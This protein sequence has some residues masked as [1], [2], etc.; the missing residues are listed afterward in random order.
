MD[1]MSGKTRPLVRGRRGV[2]AAGHPLAAS[3]GLEAFR[4][5]GGAVDAA[6]AAAAAL[7][8]VLPDACGLGGD[9]LLLVRETDGETTAIN[10]SG[11]APEGLRLPV[12]EDGAATAAVPGAVA[13]W[14][15][16]LDRFGRLG[17][18]DSLAPAAELARG[19][20]PLGDWLAAAIAAQRARLERGARGWEPLGAARPG[21]VIRQPR[22]AALLERIGHEGPAAFY[23]GG[24]AEA[25]SRA[26]AHEGGTLA[27]EDLAG[28]RTVTRDPVR[29]RYR[30]ATLNLQPP[31]SQ[32]VLLAMAL[33][34]LRDADEAD[35]HRRTHLAIEAIEA[36]FAHR[37]EPASPGAEQRLPKTKLDVDPERARRRGGPTGYAHTA[38]VTA[39]DGD[40]MLVSMLVSVFDDFGCAT[41]VP[42]GGFLL[43]DR[44]L[45]FSRDPT[46]PNAARPGARP[47]HTLSPILIENDECAIALATPGADGQVQ[48]LL[49]IVTAL[50]DEDAGLQEALERPRWR[51]VDAR[52]AVEADLEPRLKQTLSSM[53]HDVSEF[54][55]GHSLFGAAAAAGVDL[56]SGSLFAATDPRRE[57]WAAVL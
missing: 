39:A 27:A 45:G 29:T 36:A 19:G 31:V 52:L 9:T 14:S 49:Q 54:P 47:V 8:V 51:S 53:G 7:A 44:L 5:G 37:D 15:E 12:P 26:S 28:H 6:V 30:G 17:L 55:P 38:A 21:A 13:A 41:L 46:S 43:N 56:A 16:A 33:A 3:C 20:F 22:L 25:I 57:V 1:A 50:L 32:A 40:G 42:E 35:L 48:T 24:I 23:E 10:G 34:V 4:R 11:A 18:Q 2:V